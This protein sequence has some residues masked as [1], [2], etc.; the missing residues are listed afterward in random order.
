MLFES[1]SSHSS[2]QVYITCS[3]ILC[4]PGNPFSRCAQGCLGEPSRRRRR[5]LSLETTGHY[6]TQ[7]PLQLIGP[8]A[9][10]APRADKKINAAPKSGVLPEGES[11]THATV[12]VSVCVKTEFCPDCFPGNSPP[13]VPE[14]RSNEESWRFREIFASNITTVVFASG[15]ILSLVLLVVVVRHFRRRR[16]ADD[17]NFLIEDEFEK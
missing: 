9:Q 11:P 16:G 15:F 1:H 13:V 14:P 10:S 4:E 5:G 17:L 6:I 3:V 12:A 7:G 2:S 8:A